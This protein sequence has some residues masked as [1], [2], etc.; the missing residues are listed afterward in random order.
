MKLK[1]GAHKP[2][3]CPDMDC[4]NLHPIVAVKMGV[5]SRDAMTSKKMRAW[6]CES[7]S[8]MFLWEKDFEQAREQKEISI[9][10]KAYMG[11][12]SGD[13]QQRRKRKTQR[14]N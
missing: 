1:K 11:A 3:L 7:C 6:L 8:T 14:K 2:P 10:G 9:Y 13:G 4:S 5:L 12:G